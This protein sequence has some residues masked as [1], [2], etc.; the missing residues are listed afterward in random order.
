MIPPKNEWDKEYTMSANRALG[1]IGNL[2]DSYP[3]HATYK[4]C[5][6]GTMICIQVQRTPETKKR[7]F[8]L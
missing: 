2:I 4:V 1:V 5:T 3:E 7:G 8:E 6:R